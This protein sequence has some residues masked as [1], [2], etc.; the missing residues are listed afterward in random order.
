MDAKLRSITY[1]GIVDVVK[2]FAP[3]DESLPFTKKDLHDIFT[4]EACTTTCVKIDPKR[5]LRFQSHY[6]TKNPDIFVT[7]TWDLDL[8]HELPLFF[9]ELYARLLETAFISSWDEFQQL[10][11]WFD[12]LLC[13]QN[14][15]NLVDVDLNEVEANLGQHALPVEE[16]KVFVDVESHKPWADV[17]DRDVCLG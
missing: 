14:S 11:F 15:H 13:D 9:E 16:D 5:D 2:M 3:T 10:T 12:I 7:H 1:E 8:R 4:G 6:K 17:V